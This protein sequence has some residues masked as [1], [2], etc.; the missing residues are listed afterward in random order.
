[1][2]HAAFGAIGE[3]NTSGEKVD[4]GWAKVMVNNN[5]LSVGLEVAINFRQLWGTRLLWYGDFTQL[6]G[7]VSSI[8][9]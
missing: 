6:V 1:M 2:W 9:V 4:Q 8:Q 3:I 7:S 5:N